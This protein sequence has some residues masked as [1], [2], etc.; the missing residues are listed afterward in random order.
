MLRIRRPRRISRSHVEFSPIAIVGS[1]CAFGA[2]F[3]PVYGQ[4]DGSVQCQGVA[5]PVAIGNV[6][7]QKQAGI[8]SSDDQLVT[9]IRGIEV[10]IGNS[11]PQKLAFIIDTLV[12]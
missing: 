4:I 10:E 11:V 1:L 7:I 8:S 5:V 2:F 3:A 12:I 9:N 6:T